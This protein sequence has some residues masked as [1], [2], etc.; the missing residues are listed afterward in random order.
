MLFGVFKER[1]FIMKVIKVILFFS[2][3]LSAK[4]ICAQSNDPIVGVAQVIAQIDAQLVSDDASQL[5]IQDQ[6][7]DTDKSEEALQYVEDWRKAQIKSHT[8]KSGLSLSGG[9]DYKFGEGLDDFDDDLSAYRHRLNVM[10]SWDM[11]GS[12]LFGRS[13]VKQV[14]SL[15]AQKQNL[16]VESSVYAEQTYNQ[17]LEN[18]Q[19][20]EGCINKVYLEQIALYE[21]LLVLGDKLQ[22][23]GRSTK[24]EQAELSLQISMTRGLV[25]PTTVEVEHM[26][27][28]NAYIASQERM[29]ATAI[30]SLVE[31][32]S[33]IASK[34]IEEEL[35]QAEIA[36]MKYWRTVKVTPYVRAQHYSDAYFRASRVT[37]NV[38]VNATLPI[39]SGRRSKRAELQAKSMMINSAN[40]RESSALRIDISDVA[41]Q[42]N[43]NLDDLNTMLMLEHLTRRQI[44]LARESYS[45]KQMSMQELAKG[46][47]KLLDMHAN[48][49]KQIEARESLKMK[50]M[51][52]AV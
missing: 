36:Q 10:L 33:A 1:L 32:N 9:Y 31:Q 46:Y 41:M 19:F 6:I 22:G 15:E 11:L 27:D 24:L 23:E 38:G 14:A 25:R 28:I 48:I 18:L 40:E 35:L 34:R 20:I 8:S 49:I 4:S 39:F 7:A 2:I 44:E 52:T 21:S 17:N 43:R 42:L 29:E 26:L 37:A 45:R 12:G 5:T 51:L 3:I 13:S 47:I 50:L 30:E 16:N